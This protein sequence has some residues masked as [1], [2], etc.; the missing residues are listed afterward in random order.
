MTNNGLLRIVPVPVVGDGPQRTQGTQVVMPGGAPVAGVTS[1]TLVC[2]VNDVWR[3]QIECYVI[4]P[5]SLKVIP[6]MTVAHPRVVPAT[7]LRFSWWRAA[8]IRFAG[9]VVDVTDLD[10]HARKRV[11]P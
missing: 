7:A 2:A 3:A 5:E 8:L 4:P 6:T 1:I 10:V 9:G 11:K